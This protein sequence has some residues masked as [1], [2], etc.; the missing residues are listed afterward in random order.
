MTAK[1]T[2]LAIAMVVIVGSIIRI[3]ALGTNP[4][5][6][7]CDEASNGYDAYCLLET[8]RNRLGTQWPLFF[9]TLETINEGLYRY[10][11]VP[12]VAVFGLTELAVRLPAALAGT[13]T[14][15]LLFSAVRLTV[16]PRVAFL[17]AAVLAISPW[18]I[19]MSRV[20]FRAVLLPLL[21]LVAVVAAERGRAR[22]HWFLIS[23]L[24]V[25]LS[26][27]TY[28]AA[29]LFVPP[30]A[31][32]WIWRCRNELKRSLGIGLASAAVA[33]AVAAPVVMMW[34]SPIG[35]ARPSL[36]LVDSPWQFV[37]NYG[38]YF[39][40]SFLFFDGD[41]N[42]RHGVPG[43]GQLHIIEMVTISVGM[44]VLLRRWRKTYPWIVW[45]LASPLASAL[46]EP[47]QALRSVSLAVG[48]AVVSATGIDTL[49]RLAPD[50]RIRI[51]V[52]AGL[53][54]IV[55]INV[56]TFG[57]LYF[58]DYP[59]LS[60]GAWQYGFRDALAI[61]Q[62]AEWPCVYLSHEL[63]ASHL[64]VLFYTKWP[65][66]DYQSRAQ[67]A[68]DG[69]DAEIVGYQL[70]KYQIADLE[71]PLTV[72]DRCLVI[73]TPWDVDQ[74]VEAGDG[75]YTIEDVTWF[76]N[77]RGQVAMAVMGLHSAPKSQH[78]PPPDLGIE[79]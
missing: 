48:L 39:S 58:I 22:S 14:I 31:A 1:Q 64:L 70:G 74:V 30:V 47:A 63:F 25:G 75:S 61:A 37:V 7:F 71:Q 16:E 50:R 44:F 46:T 55:G 36:L 40:P 68:N 45:V 65:P 66:A 19:V 15:L 33:G 12:S 54:L 34:V 18:H 42:L 17:S 6:L 41:P 27:H 73:A 26:M 4:P 35:M 67:P 69:G 3:H 78:D 49:V 76:G 23:G 43:L 21:M 13:L 24:A 79:Q 62:T 9:P 20:G 2:A 28:V 32:A 10:L 60:I 51:V 72:R 8:G 53:A 5:G 52:T 38:S 11:M 59:E 77:N 29:A 56:A 57:V